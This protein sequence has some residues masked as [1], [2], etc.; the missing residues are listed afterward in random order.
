MI[1]L[2]AP[3]TIEAADA[4]ESAIIE[5]DRTAMRGIQMAISIAFED[6]DSIPEEFAEVASELWAF[7]VEG[8]QVDGDK[9]FFGDRPSPEG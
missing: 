8:R 6:E 9:P 1:R 2:L 4:G 7:F 5:L 3:T